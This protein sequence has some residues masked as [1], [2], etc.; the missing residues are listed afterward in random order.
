MWCIE[1]SVSGRRWISRQVQPIHVMYWNNSLPRVSP[2]LGLFNRYMWCI[3]ITPKSMSSSLISE[4]TFNRYMWCIEMKELQSIGQQAIKFNRYM[5]CI[6][7]ANR[8]PAKHRNKCVQPIHVMYWNS[9]NR[10]WLKLPLLFNRY[11]WCIEIVF[12]RRACVLEF[13]QPIHVMYWNRS[14]NIDRLRMCL[15]QPIHV[16]YW[17][18][19]ISCSIH[20]PFLFNRYMWCIEIE[21]TRRLLQWF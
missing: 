14:I 1:I 17:N 10:H 12:V 19:Q 13:V 4:D 15:V 2:A 7:I 21:W 18:K 8:R 6:E 5:W 20:S 11:M 3:E 9:H 16:M